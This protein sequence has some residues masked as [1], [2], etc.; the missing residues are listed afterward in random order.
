MRAQLFY[1][2]AP[3]GDAVQIANQQNCAQ[4]TFSSVNTHLLSGILS[5]SSRYF[6]IAVASPGCR[7]EMAAP[8]THLR[9]APDHSNRRGTL[10][11]L[12]RLVGWRSGRREGTVELV[13]L[14]G[15]HGNGE[16]QAF[17]LASCLMVPTS[18][19]LKPIARFR[20]K[21]CIVLV[22]PVANI[23]PKEFPF[24]PGY[25]CGFSIFLKS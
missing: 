10:L 7:T 5:S 3:A 23:S 24:V 22:F 2:P 16:I 11:D 12:Q 18:V 25:E 15:D 4:D 21:G 8:E 1:Q 14:W 20:G 17:R 9:V 6:P 19:V 13:A